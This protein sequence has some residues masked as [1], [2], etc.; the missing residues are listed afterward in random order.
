MLYVIY[1]LISTY[2]VLKFIN[3]RTYICISFCLIST[4]DVL[5]LHNQRHSRKET[6]RLIS[7]YDVLKYIIDQLGGEFEDV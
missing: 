1:C 4:Y 2:D 5:K 3:F 6:R 7:T